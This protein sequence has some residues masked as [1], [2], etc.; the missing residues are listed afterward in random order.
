VDQEAVESLP[1]DTASE[2]EITQEPTPPP[3]ATD[4]PEPTSTLIPPTPTAPQK[5]ELTDPVEEGLPGYL[6]VTSLGYYITGDR[7]VVELVFRD[8]PET[9]TFNRPHVQVNRMEYKWDVYVD[10]DDDV[11]TGTDI[12]GQEGAEY[13]LSAAYY[14]FEESDPTDAK[15]QEMVQV[16]VGE[17]KADSPGWSFLERAEIKVQADE[18]R[19]I[20]SGRIPE[21]SQESR[22]FFQTMESHPEQGFV[23]DQME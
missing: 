11:Q 23:M 19:M 6:D 13:N 22:L 17:H 1:P 3:P 18:N 14:L 15:I 9:L 5:T 10:V 8:L 21:I 7:L 4:I 16:N 2:A 20:I 12:I